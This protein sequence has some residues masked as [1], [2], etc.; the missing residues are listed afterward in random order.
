MLSHCG[1]S[2]RLREGLDIGAVGE[3]WFLRLR[4]SLVRGV[5]MALRGV[6]C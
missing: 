3:A 1:N 6:K 4:G 5:D 2:R